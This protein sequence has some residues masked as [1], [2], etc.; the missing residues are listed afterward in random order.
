MYA[1]ILVPVAF[2]HETDTLRAL[3]AA[4]RLL[5]DGGQVT[6]VHIVEAIPPYVAAQI[7]QEVHQGVRAKSIEMLEKAATG[8]DLKVNCEVVSGHPAR[9]ILD[10]AQ[11]SECDCIIIASHDPG[12]EDYF[13]GSTAARV[14]RHAHCSV[15]VLR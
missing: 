9:A 3:D 4:G 15:L 14:V 13:L 7:S 1:H 10:F 5:A 6:L 11:S 12:L 8:S 2:D